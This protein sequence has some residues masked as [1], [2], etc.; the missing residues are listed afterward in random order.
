MTTSKFVKTERLYHRDHPQLTERWVQDRIAEDPGMLGLGD[1]VIRDR[2]RPQP[3]AGRLDLLL[4]D[5]DTL[6]RYELELQL[7]RTDECHI[8][9]TIE[10]WDVERK[11][12]PQYEHC[13]VLVAEDITSRFFSII[14]L[15]NGSIPLMAVQMSAFAV[16]GGVALTFTTV[17]DE[18]KRGLVDEDEPI[19]EPADRAYWETRGSK[20]TV[21]VA[22]ELL[23]LIRNFAP[24]F[25]LRYN[26]HYIGLAQNGEPMHF[27]VFRARRG[28]MNVEIRLPQSS[29]WQDR[30]EK[31]GIDLL[32]Y[33]KRWGAYEL[34]LS[35]G[36]VGQHSAFL[37][38]LL[39][40]A[41]ED[42]SA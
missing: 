20:A 5:P 29:E 32:E 17:L 23:K 38:E 37:M 9:R 22:D 34:K 39:R 31:A 42:R 13:A 40:A 30:L 2:E 8:I 25:E 16:D 12:Y 11:R 35:P 4:Q 19:Q 24:G 33:D 14:G 1:L 27:A 3:R 6:R 36:D 18:L 7:G 26:R 15:F 21:A 41:Y 28:S 10:Y